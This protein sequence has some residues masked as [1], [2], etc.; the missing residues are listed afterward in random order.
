[1]GMVSKPK[2]LGERVGE[3]V[4]GT[5]S[6]PAAHTDTLCPSLCGSSSRAHANQQPDMAFIWEQPRKRPLIRPA[7]ADENAGYRVPIPVSRP[8]VGPPTLSRIA[9]RRFFV[10]T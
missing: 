8:L 4:S 2:L 7:T 3:R 6:E 5:L 10:T 9:Y 1:M